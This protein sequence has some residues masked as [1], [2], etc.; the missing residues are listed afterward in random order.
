MSNFV[1]HLLTLLV[2]DLLVFILVKFRY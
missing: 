2:Q 1:L